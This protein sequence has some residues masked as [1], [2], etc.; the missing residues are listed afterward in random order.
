M[1]GFLAWLGDILAWRGG[2]GA[3]CAAAGTAKDAVPASSA[4]AIAQ[5]AVFVVMVKVLCW[6]RKSEHPT[7]PRP[8]LI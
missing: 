6:S 7:R 4:T 3:L 2:V 8:G 1:N 5:A